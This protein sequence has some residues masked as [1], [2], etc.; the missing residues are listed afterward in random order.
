[1]FQLT[2]AVGMGPVLALKYFRYT[3]RSSA[4]N[5]LQQAEHLRGPILSLGNVEPQKRS[6]EKDTAVLSITQPKS[7]NP[8]YEPLLSDSPTATRRSSLGPTAASFEF[9]QAQSRL[10]S[11]YSRNCKNN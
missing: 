9:F 6:M 11:T 7:R 10:S 1:M 3:Y 5:K 4:I 8:V 2:V